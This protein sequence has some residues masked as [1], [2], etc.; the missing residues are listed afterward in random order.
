MCNIE[1][2]VGD[3]PAALGD[4]GEAGRAEAVAAH[5]R[6]LPEERERLGDEVEVVV[7]DGHPLEAD[8]LEARVGGAE[9]GHPGG[10]VGAPSVGHEAEVREARLALE[11]DGAQA[12]EALDGAAR[13][14]GV[15]V[16]DEE[17]APRLRLGA[18]PGAAD[19]RGGVAVPRG[20]EELEHAL[21]HVLQHLV[22]RRP[23]P[24]PSV[25]SPQIR[26][27]PVAAA[28]SSSARI[29]LRH[30][31]RRRVGVVLRRVPHAGRGRGRGRARRRRGC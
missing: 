30:L 19:E 10:D 2:K 28:P 25:A 23:P 22:R 8:A 27:P 20:G 1:K 12:A 15:A 6:E 11:H 7:G 18:V 3:V 26:L 29:V 14:D 9:R 31:R 16:A 21:E 13:R 5:E 4:E 24:G 17:V